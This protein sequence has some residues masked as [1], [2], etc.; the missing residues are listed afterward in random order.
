MLSS[1]YNA[2]ISYIF[3]QDPLLR[4]LMLRPFAL[5]VLTK[6]GMIFVTSLVEMEHSLQ[7]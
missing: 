4:A 5:L 1:V 7:F 6:T 3:R 2:V